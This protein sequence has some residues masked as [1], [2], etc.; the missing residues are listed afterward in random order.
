MSQSPLRTGLLGL[1]SE[2]GA[3]EGMRVAVLE[4]IGIPRLP[5]RDDYS[6]G[7]GNATL[8]LQGR[9]GYNGLRRW[10]DA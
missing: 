6:T 2:R 8:R 5:R 4:E 3:G 7:G 1:D 10:Q 9:Q